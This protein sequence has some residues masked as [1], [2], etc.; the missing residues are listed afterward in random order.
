MGREETSGG[1]KD[2]GKEGRKERGGGRREGK[3]RQGRG[4]PWDDAREGGRDCRV[5]TYT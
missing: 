5:Y 1:G 4:W 2:G 3:K